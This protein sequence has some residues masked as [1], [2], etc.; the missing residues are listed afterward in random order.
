M[1]IGTGKMGSDVCRHFESY[2]SKLRVGFSLYITNRTHE[3]SQKLATEIPSLRVLDFTS[4]I[5][6]LSNF[7]LVISAVSTS[8]PIINLDASSLT[9]GRLLAILDLGVPRSVSKGYL[10]TDC[11]IY[12]IDF[13]EE[14][15][16]ATLKQRQ[17]AISDIELIIN[18][19][20]EEFSNWVN[21]MQLSPV[22][23]EL[24]NELEKIR[25]D[26]LSRYL[27]KLDESQHSVVDSLTRDLINKILRTPVVQLKQACQRGEIGTMV[28]T[29]R[30][31]FDISKSSLE[32][33]KGGVLAK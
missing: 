11:E 9:N 29:L 19:S 27:K 6:G 21:T 17:G 13:I 15:T 10:S 33:S 12:N 30:A 3:K 25:K 18:E 7:D 26:E 5:H 14:R 24:K 1:V 2:Q 32:V 22:I 20:I 4:A 23:T 16:S 8:K 31:L 28:D